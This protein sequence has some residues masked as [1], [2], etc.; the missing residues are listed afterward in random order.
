MPPLVSVII[1]AYQEPACLNGLLA[2]LREQTHPHLEILIVDDASGKPF[3]DQYLLPDNARLI[4]NPE[5]RALPALSRNTAMRQ[6]QG[7]FLA[8]VDQDDRWHPEKLARQA[9]ALQTHPDALMHYTHVA[10]VDP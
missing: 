6:A 8:F 9:A 10:K 7:E 3:T 1:L 2:S 4:I 5:R